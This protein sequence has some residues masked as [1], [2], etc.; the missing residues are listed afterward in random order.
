MESDL[1][2]NLN[3]KKKALVVIISVSIVFLVL[4][5]CGHYLSAVAQHGDAQDTKIEGRTTWTLIPNDA[6][7]TTDE[8]KQ[9]KLMELEGKDA[10]ELLEFMENH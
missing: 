8:E 10:Q 6:F 3:M 5:I 2:E 4:F 9:K 1:M 7:H